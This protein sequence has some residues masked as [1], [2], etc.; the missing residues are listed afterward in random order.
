MSL[1]HYHGARLG[2]TRRTLHKRSRLEFGGYGGV[3]GM[4][5]THF[6]GI[7]KVLR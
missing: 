1:N 5:D 3:I 7:F 2:N 6:I 4:D